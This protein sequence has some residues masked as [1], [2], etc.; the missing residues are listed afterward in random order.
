MAAVHVS[1]IHVNGDG[2]LVSE[3]FRHN[4]R[5]TSDGNQRA[6]AVNHVKLY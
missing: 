6:N 4:T 1:F 3:S 2:S 5:S